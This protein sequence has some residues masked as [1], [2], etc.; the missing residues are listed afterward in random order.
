MGAKVSNF[1]CALL[2]V[3]GL[4]MLASCDQ[5]S[6]PDLGNPDA[7]MVFET[8]LDGCLVEPNEYEITAASLSKLGWTQSYENISLNQKSEHWV[9]LDAYRG[10]PGRSS[11]PEL[12]REWTFYDSKDV[13]LGFWKLNCSISMLPKDLQWTAVV[14]ALEDHQAHMQPTGVIEDGKKNEATFSFP[15]KKE[16]IGHLVITQSV[17]RGS[18]SVLVQVSMPPTYLPLSVTEY[19]AATFEPTREDQIAEMFWDLCL[20]GYPQSAEE[21]YARAQKIEWTYLGWSM[22]H[23]QIVRPAPQWTA[24]FAHTRS[25]RCDLQLKVNRKARTFRCELKMQPYCSRTD[26]Y[27]INLRRLL[28]GGQVLQTL[29]DNHSI[30]VNETATVNKNGDTFKDDRYRILR[31]AG[32]PTN[33]E[34]QF[35]GNQAREGA[36][37]T[38]VAEYDLL[39][40]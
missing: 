31:T 3:L 5:K 12:K 40:D 15:F 32:Q 37:A 16:G 26:K 6:R 8:L 4:L 19:L 33:L 25:N 39:S 38:L 22:T 17:K 10:P 21:I 18:F 2:S 29:L 23:E 27:P 7:Q 1:N 34:I 24:V 14:S 20:D 11:T 35:I 36:D 9:N 28:S 13:T 30:V